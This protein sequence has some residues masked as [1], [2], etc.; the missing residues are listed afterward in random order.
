MSDDKR[1]HRRYRRFAKAIQ[2]GLVL[3]ILTSLCAL[4]AAQPSPLSFVDQPLPP[5]EV[6]VEF[7]LLLHAVGGI[8]PYVWSVASGDLPEGITLSADGLLSGRPT[9][10]GGF[11]VTLKLEDS[12]HPAHT[13]NKDF[14]AVVGGSLSFEWID[15]PKVH[16]NRIDGTMQVSNGSTATYDMTV[17]VVAIADNG[18]ATAIGYQHFPLKPNSDSVKIPFGNTLPFGGY[19]VHADAIAEIPERKTILR[20]SLQTPQPLQILQGP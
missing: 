7:H 8:P 6:G 2:F 11:T 17:Y 18:R 19:I 1:D 14:H 20:Q 12:A 16:D 13:V 5:I 9:K 4:A 15:P 3:M 10:A